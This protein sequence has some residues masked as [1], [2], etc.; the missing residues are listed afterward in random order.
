MPDVKID[1]NIPIAAKKGGRPSASEIAARVSLERDKPEPQT[2]TVWL[3]SDGYAKL[4]V[5][6]HFFVHTVKEKHG[7]AFIFECAET[8]TK[9]RFGL[10]E[11]F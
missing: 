10:Q 11:A 1:E 2:K 3:A 7:W 9:R 4:T 8:G 6:K 5:T